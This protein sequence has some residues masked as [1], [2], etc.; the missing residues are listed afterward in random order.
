MSE[1]SP[2]IVM[3]ETTP[4]FRDGF[5]FA[6]KCIYDMAKHRNDYSLD[7]LNETLSSII[8]LMDNDS[9]WPG[10]KHIIQRDKK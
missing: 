4:E 10:I 5:E 7:K 8:I 9:W 3:R 6:V 2:G 1:E